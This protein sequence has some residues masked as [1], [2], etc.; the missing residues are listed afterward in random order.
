MI[1]WCKRSIWSV[2]ARE[3]Q[4]HL[5]GIDAPFHSV[6]YSIPGRI[7]HRKCVCLLS[8]HSFNRLACQSLNEVEFGFQFAGPIAFRW[9]SCISCCFRLFER[10]HLLQ[11]I[12]FSLPNSSYSATTEGHIFRYENSFTSSLSGGNVCLAWIF[13]TF[14][15]QFFLKFCRTDPSFINCEIFRK[16]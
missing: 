8:S 2:S 4:I 5:L 12:A 1:F 3:I 6:F 16:I 14:Q 7:P 13:D 15:I 9:V 11:R 10:H